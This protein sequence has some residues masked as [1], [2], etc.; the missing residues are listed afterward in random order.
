MQITTERLLLR[1]IHQKDAGAVFA[2]RSDQ[3]TNQYQGWIPETPED[4]VDFIQ[5][6]VCAMMNRPGTWVQLVV[7]SKQN[8]TIIGDVGIHFLDPEGYQAELGCTIAKNYHGHGYATEAMCAIINFLFNE[9][10]KHRITASIDPRNTASIKLVERLGFRLEA[11]FRES[12]LLNGVW[13]DDLVYGIL[14][15]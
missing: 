7:V 5:N 2:Y 4:M 6:K 13:V 1:P 14:K 15:N 8:G 10:N 9:L 11:H 3:L 12:L